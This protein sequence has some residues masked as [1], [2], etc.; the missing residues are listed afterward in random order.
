MKRFIVF[1]VM[2]FIVIPNAYGLD[3]EARAPLVFKY[4]LARALY[5]D[6]IKLLDDFTKSKVES[7]FAEK[8]LSEWK[9]QYNEKM[10]PV[11][12]EARKMHSSMNKVINLTREIIHEYQPNN[13]N[14]EDMLSELNELKDQLKHEMTQLW[15]WLK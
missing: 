6:V 11:Q 7:R 10:E 1:L 5:I 8:K 13:Q 2:G 14:T 15:Y 4:N 3:G 9:T 12:E